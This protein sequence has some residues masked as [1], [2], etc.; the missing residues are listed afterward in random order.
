MHL[1]SRVLSVA[2]LC[3]GLAACFTSDEPLIAGGDADFPFERIVFAEVSRA[4]DPQTWIHKGD[5]YSWRPDANDEREAVMRLKAVGDDLYVVQMSFTERDQPE[6]LYAL[7]KADLPAK[8]VTSYAGIKPDAF[9][10][11]PGLG[12]CESTVCIESLDAYVAYAK[13][14]IDAGDKPDAEYKIIEME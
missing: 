5:A 12:L 7:L 1:A 2:F 3:L 13:S 4:D 6:L 9:A 8:R 14:R 10:A 11:Q